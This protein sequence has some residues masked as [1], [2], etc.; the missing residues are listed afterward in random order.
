MGLHDGS[1]GRSPGLSQFQGGIRIARHKDFFNA[2]FRRTEFFHHLINA[3]EYF[4]QARRNLL[5]G[6]GDSTESHR[7]G[8]VSHHI[9]HA[10]TG[11]SR[12]G[13]NTQNKRHIP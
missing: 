5:V 4:P 3:R 8:T 9:H 1:N 6:S 2:D 7:A 10:V 11:A 12:A 13:I